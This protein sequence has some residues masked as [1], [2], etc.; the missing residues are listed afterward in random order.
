M[1]IHATSE[2]LLW[3]LRRLLPNVSL[4]VTQERPWYSLTFTGTQLCIAVTVSG[5]AHR[6]VAAE[7]AQ[8]LP[9]YDFSL[10]AQLVA[11]IA[12]SKH[13]AG[14]NESCLTVHALLLDD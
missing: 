1:T 13:I 10:G 12:V 6:Q 8:I 9:E 7:Y 3:A 14:D 2:A 11:D 5:K 4:S